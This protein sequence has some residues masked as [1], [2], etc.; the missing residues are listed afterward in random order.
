M[1]KRVLVPSL[2]VKRLIKLFDSSPSKMTKGKKNV[3]STKSATALAHMA[4]ELGIEEAAASTEL[5]AAAANKSSRNTLAAFDSSILAA[6]KSDS[7]MMARDGLQRRLSDGAAGAGAGTGQAAGGF[8]TPKGSALAPSGMASTPKG[9][10]AGMAKSSIMRS[11]LNIGEKPTAKR[12]REE[13][14][15][16]P[17][18]ANKAKRTT[19]VAQ[20]PLQRPPQQQQQQGDQQ[21]QGQEYQTWQIELCD[22]M[23][24]MGGDAIPKELYKGFLD[25]FTATHEE[26]VMVQAHAIAKEV[27][28]KESESK[29]CRRSLLI[30]NVDKWIEADKETE[31]HG[32]ADRA[33]AAVHKL[34]CGMVTVQEAFPV[35]QCLPLRSI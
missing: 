5:A 25:L 1:P 6:K 30:H 29:K 18:L 15:A 31:G 33:T 12:N 13:C 19:E 14:A 9:G 23:R 10:T 7:D 2:K 28:Y 3:T 24:A 22:K 26:R 4:E 8:H 20:P 34:T 17:Q 16:S 32:L 21:Q 27:Y 35:G 11:F